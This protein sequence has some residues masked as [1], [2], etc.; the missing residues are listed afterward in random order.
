MEE[1]KYN[2]LC[3]LFCQKAIFASVFLTLFSEFY[4]FGMLSISN[5]NNTVKEDLQGAIFIRISHKW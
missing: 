4:L 2:N 5:S 3:N 1:K